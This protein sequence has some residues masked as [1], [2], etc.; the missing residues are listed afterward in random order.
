MHVSA[1]VN[2]GSVDFTFL[3]APSFS[4]SHL[5]SERQVVNLRCENYKLECAQS[6][7]VPAAAGNSA[8]TNHK[9]VIEMKRIIILF[10]IIP[11]NILLGQDKVCLKR[12]VDSFYINV[13]LDEYFQYLDSLNYSPRKYLSLVKVNKSDFGKKDYT[14][15]VVMQKRI[16]QN[17][18]KKYDYYFKYKGRYIVLVGNYRIKNIRNDNWIKPITAKDKSELLNQLYDERKTG[19]RFRTQPSLIYSP[20]GDFNHTYFLQ[21][22]E[23]PELKSPFL[24]RKMYPW[25][26]MNLPIDTIK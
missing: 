4:Q 20:H 21:L 2:H 13:A 25:L 15:S 9:F 23:I 11:G 18:V 26:F 24:I 6:R 3:V 17:Y 1:E 19:V 10:F 16:L 12:D 5:V 7:R 22:K 14:I 8:K